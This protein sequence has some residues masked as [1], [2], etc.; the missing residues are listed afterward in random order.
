MNAL[1]KRVTKLE[2]TSQDEGVPRVEL[3]I[4]QDGE[5]TRECIARHGQDPDDEGLLCIVVQGVKP[6]G[7]RQHAEWVAA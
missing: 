2:G 7:E 3:V 5:T 6:T 4:M 1:E